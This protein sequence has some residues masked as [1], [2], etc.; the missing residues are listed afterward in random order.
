MEMMYLIRFDGCIDVNVTLKS[1]QCHL[2]LFR[3]LLVTCF[4]YSP[5]LRPH[6]CAP[7]AVFCQLQVRILGMDLEKG[8]LDVTMDTDLVKVSKA[9]K[10][11]R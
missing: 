5:F 1:R 2:G 6:W 10:S 3:T 4:R 11:S 7:W 8:V 9:A